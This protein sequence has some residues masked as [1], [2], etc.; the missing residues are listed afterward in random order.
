M[1]SKEDQSGGKAPSFAF[2]H[3]Y[4]PQLDA[5]RG[6]QFSASAVVRTPGSMRPQRGWRPAATYT[7]TQPAAEAA[8]GTLTTSGPL[9]ENSAVL[10]M[11][12]WP[13]M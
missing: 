10:K 8:L 6:E 12:P 7:A 5:G 4:N 2:A 1:A 13:C 9:A 3:V 11:M